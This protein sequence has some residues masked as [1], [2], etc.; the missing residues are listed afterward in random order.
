MKRI[1]LLLIILA[2]SFAFPGFSQDVKRLTLEDVINLAA[3]QSPNALIAKHRFRASYWQYRT[4]VAEYRPSLML[5]GTLP[6]Y[7]TAYNRV[8]NSST[9]QY[10]YA[11]VNVL[12]NQASLSLTQ[13]IGPTG[14]T[15]SL[16]SDLTY[17]IDLEHDTTSISHHR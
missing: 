11:S 9:Q 3:E 16:N 14:G 2:V 5:S 17:E 4:F 1:K 7:S 6:N 8:W 10:E 15:I 13:N 12:Q